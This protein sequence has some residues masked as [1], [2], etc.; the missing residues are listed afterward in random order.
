[1]RAEE[2]RL[3]NYVYSGVKMVKVKSIHTESVLK[4]EVSIYIE[5]NENLRHYCVSMDDIKPIK[6][7]EEILLKCGFEYRPCGIQGAD[8]WQGLAYW[9]LSGVHLRGNKKIT[10]PLKIQGLINS[11]IKYLHQLQNLF[12]VLSGKE[13]EINGL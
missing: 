10:N 9:D 6:L 11:E 7:T 8:M 3:N 12:F 5:L 2:L 1:M 13:L 4:D